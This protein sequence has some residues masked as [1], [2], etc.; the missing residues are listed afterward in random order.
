MESGSGHWGT[1]A[2]P[3]GNF[4]GWGHAPGVTEETSPKE[5]PNQ[6]GPCWAPLVGG[7][8]VGGGLWGANRHGRET[9]REDKL[10]WQFRRSGLFGPDCGA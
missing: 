8:R 3:F 5:C 10:P 2:R 9:G 6:L 4:G 1:N 7:F